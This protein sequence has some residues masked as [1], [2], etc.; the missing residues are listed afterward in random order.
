MKHSTLY[1]FL[2]LVLVMS[3]DTVKDLQPKQNLNEIIPEV[4]VQSLK[5]NYPEAKQIRMLVMEKSKIF[6]SDFDYKSDKMSAI[7]NYQGII[8]E[9]Y[10]ESNESILPEGS[11]IYLQNNYKDFTI[12]SVKE[13]ITQESN[14][15]G[16]RV[17]VK[18]EK[19]TNT[20]LFFDKTGTITFQ[21]ADERNMPFNTPPPRVFFIPVNEIP[22]S[23]HE[24]LKQ[25]HGD[26]EWV[27]T[28]AIIQNDTKNYLVLVAKDLV[29]YDYLFDEKANVLRKN[30][31][32]INAPPNL[33]E[34]KNL[35]FNELNSNI[36]NYLNKELKG[37]KFE[38]GIVFYQNEKIQGYNI[39]VTYIG[40]QYALLF[41]D[42]GNYVRTEQLGFGNMPPPKNNNIKKIEV[43]DLPI[44]IS[45]YL[46]N[47][48]SSFKYV[49]ASIIQENNKK[50]YWILIFANNITVDFTFDE[51]GNV[52]N[53]KE[54]D[55]KFS[56]RNFEHK[57]ILLTDI[58]K[59][60]IDFLDKN[61]PKW[62]FNKAVVI[63][64]VNKIIGYLVSIRIGNEF[65]TIQFDENAKF[66]AARRA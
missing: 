26:F 35:N 28:G 19:G 7:I 60:A 40:K 49:Q 15:L 32:G 59:N 12:N 30:T 62:T 3:C 65:Y 45:N 23:I 41:D 36:L 18:N 63:M 24:A 51:S 52:L 22:N 10:K 1:I 16:F 43:K 31:F 29:S 9:I 48:Y 47:K 58:P 8:T 11:K 44:T 27:K 56:P 25:K 37:W 61:Y 55:F 38:K 50:T 42:S 4:V 5:A 39:I 33:I 21:V 17:M 66:L 53:M 64:D 14:T 34:D 13:Q 54:I 6:Q 20:D 46:K 2:F 57:G